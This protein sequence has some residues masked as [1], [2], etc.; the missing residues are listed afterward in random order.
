MFIEQF[1]IGFMVLQGT[2]IDGS[3]ENIA[4]WAYSEEVSP[5]YLRFFIFSRN[6]EKSTQ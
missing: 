5:Q 1:V 4:F 2:L 6:S 3:L